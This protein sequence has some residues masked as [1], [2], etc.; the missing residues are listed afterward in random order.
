MP[1]INPIAP[2]DHIDAAEPAPL[3][4]SPSRNSMPAPRKPMPP[5]TPLITLA[6]SIDRLVSADVNGSSITSSPS[7]Q[8]LSEMITKGR[9]STGFL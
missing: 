1:Q 4:T 5:M 6:G 2:A 8:E 7:P 3:T 9:K